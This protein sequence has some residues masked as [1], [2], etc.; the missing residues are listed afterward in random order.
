VPFYAGSHLLAG[1]EVLT[2]IN[3]GLK[4]FG[5]LGSAEAFSFKPALHPSRLY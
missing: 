5:K 1:L 2:E 3:S 4:V